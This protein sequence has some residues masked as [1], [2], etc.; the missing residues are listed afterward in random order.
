LLSN[1]NI[2]TK[3]IGRAAGL[4]L[5]FLSLNLKAQNLVYNPSFE[6]YSSCPIQADLDFNVCTRWFNPTNPH[7]DGDIITPWSSP[8]YFNSC[9]QNSDNMF[10]IPINIFGTQSPR[11]GSGYTGII[12]GAAFI[13]NPPDG[14][15]YR[16]Y[17]EGQLTT[18]LITGKNYCVGFYISLA[19][20]RCNYS[21]D[22][23]G[24]YFS[25]DSLLSAT[26]NSIVVTPQIENQ[27][28]NYLNDTTN[29]IKFSGTF[30]AIGGERFITIGNFRNQN[31]TNYYNLN[32]FPNYPDNTSV[33]YYIDDVSVTDCGVGIEETQTPPIYLYPNPTTNTVTLNYTFKQAATIEVYSINGACLLKQ[34]IQ[35]GTQNPI[36]DVSNL[37]NGLYVVR[38]YTAQ[39]PLFNQRLAIVK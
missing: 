29:W 6:E 37:A 32:Y 16:E 21:T 34:P 25:S 4:A 5:L 1:L 7:D 30:T 12:S 19:G 17:I 20:K 8:D 13:S 38:A 26:Q 28:N 2:L 35:A 15:E 39:Q 18:P 36:V 27:I 3:S 14:A 31:S 10:G 24:I 23:I 22:M 11:S 33:Y 9:Y